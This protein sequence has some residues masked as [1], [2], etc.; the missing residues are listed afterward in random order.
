MEIPIKKRKHKHGNVIRSEDLVFPEE[1]PT[2]GLLLLLLLLCCVGH[3]V[4]LITLYKKNNPLN[5]CLSFY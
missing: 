2:L 3:F 4:V 1:K 5:P